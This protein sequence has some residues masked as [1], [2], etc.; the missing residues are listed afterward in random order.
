[1]RIGVGVV[2][3]GVPRRVG[4]GVDHRHECRQVAEL[5][6]QRAGGGRADVPDRQRH[7]HPPQGLAA[8]RLE[9]GQQAGAVGGQL[10]VLAGEQGHG[11]QRGLVQV[12]H[13]ALVA[14]RPGGEQRRRG[15]PAHRLDVEG[16]AGR[17][18]EQPLAQLG[19]ARAGVRAADVDVALFG[20]GEQ[21]A[22]AADV[23]RAVRGHHER[24]GL[25]GPQVDDRPEHLGD[26]VTGLAQHD[27]V[28]DQDT[29]AGHLGGVVQRGHLDGRPT[30]QHRLHHR[31]G[32]HPTGTADVDPDVEQ[33][34]RDLLRGVLVR[35]RPP[36]GAAGGA[37]AAL[38]R[39]LVDLDDDPVD[40]VLDG[41]PLL[42]HPLDVRDDVRDVVEHLSV[43]AG[44]QAPGS[45]PVV[46]LRLA[47]DL[48]AAPGAQAVHHQPQGTAGRDPRVL[49]AQRPR[50]RVAGVGERRAAG[51][52]EPGVQVG[53]RRDREVHLTAH[54]DQVG[55]GA[56]IC[57]EHGRHAAQGADVHGH[58][59]AGAAVAAG[60]G[61]HQPAALVDQVDGEPV[62][63]GL[64][65]PMDV[66]A[67]GIAH[68]PLGPG[69][70][71]VG[72]EHVVEAEHP[73]EMV[74]RGE[75]GR[76]RA[77]DDLAGA[78][79]GAQPRVL[80]LERLE[81]AHQLIEGAVAERRGSANVVGEPVGGDLL[82][83][84][85]PPVSGL[86]RDR[87]LGSTAHPRHHARDHRPPLPVS[88][89]TPR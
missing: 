39:D 49:L 13:V 40:L 71:L 76:E 26:D 68:H 4:A 12:E 74:D 7:D 56:I 6:G 28:A 33:Q 69:P 54:L 1:M 83:Q 17:E 55:H 89:R 67:V 61:A 52:D 36:R 66:G 18:R 41:V 24:A 31:V 79:R 73:L 44:G 30:D 22:A 25:G 23:H 21:G 35:N 85:G 57:G 51:L 5:G 84:L 70:Q 29:L 87:R 47:G 64:A 43:P 16:P 88:S 81:L 48:D 38:H 75:L 34:R 46:G 19:W 14:H 65:Q 42:A 86:A 72:A 27:G 37:Q 8:G 59:L 45:E 78:V 15:L 3:R 50:G 53:E 58:V 32:R 10:S 60:R 20:G 77:A 9:V 62:D 82:G 11:A 80:V 63:L 2:V